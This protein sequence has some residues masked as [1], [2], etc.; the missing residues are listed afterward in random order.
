[1]PEV[2]HMIEQGHDLFKISRALKVPVA[3]LQASKE[4]Q[5]MFKLYQDSFDVATCK[6][7]DVEQAKSLY[8]KGNTLEHIARIFNIDPN[9][10]LLNLEFMSYVEANKDFLSTNVEKEIDY[11]LLGKLAA[12]QCTIGEIANVMQLSYSRLQ[13]DTATRIITE[14]RE[15]GKASLRRMQWACAEKGNV[16]ML[17]FLGKQYLN[18]NER[19]T[20]EESGQ[21]V[22]F[23]LPV[24]IEKDSEWEDTFK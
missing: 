17:M 9:R 2:K 10:L 1:M 14:K 3:L 22:S 19:G 16:Q 18:Q 8:I 12:L 21:N 23:V 7:F 11:E 20:A 24:P 5:A 13:E 15:A 4:V 6:T